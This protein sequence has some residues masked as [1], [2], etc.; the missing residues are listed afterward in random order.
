MSNCSEAQTAVLSGSGFLCIDTPGSKCAA[1]Y[2]NVLTLWSIDAVTKRCVAAPS[3]SPSPGA[4][5]AGNASMSPCALDAVQICPSPSIRG[6]AVSCIC[7]GGASGLGTSNTSASL[8]GRTAKSGVDCSDAVLCFFTTSLPYALACVG[9]AAIVI[10]IVLYICKAR[11]CPGTRCVPVQPRCCCCCRALCRPTPLDFGDI[12]VPLEAA[13]PRVRHSRFA[14]KASPA[15]RPRDLELTDVDARAL[16]AM[17]QGILVDVKAARE[18]SGAGRRRLSPTKR[19]ASLGCEPRRLSH[20]DRRHSTGDGNDPA[21]SWGRGDRPPPPAPGPSEEEQLRRTM[22]ASLRNALAASMSSTLSRTS[23]AHTLCVALSMSDSAA[24]RG[25]LHPERALDAATVASVLAALA[26]SS[27]GLREGLAAA[28]ERPEPQPVDEG[29]GQSA[30]GAAG[31][32]EPRRH[33]R[34]HRKHKDRDDGEGSAAGAE[35]DNQADA[36]L[37]VEVISTPRSL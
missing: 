20:R 33:H 31:T 9:A 3:A 10:V 30:E 23:L 5:S 11:C 16:A 15:Q 17:L 26:R 18:T 34:R 7:V 24:D 19:R 27:P 37:D 35:I 22:E 14:Q 25:A 8:S 28:L 32:K 4:A 13:R 12:E 1:L 36:T 6:A 2:P 21:A 29:D